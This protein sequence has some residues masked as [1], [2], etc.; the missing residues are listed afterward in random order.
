MWTWKIRSGKS[1]DELHVIDALVA[2]VAR[3]V[4]EA[5]CRVIADRLEGA[6]GEGDVER[7]F[8]GMHF[9]GVADAVV[10][11]LVEDRPEALGEVFVSAV[12]LAGQVRREAV[13]EVP[14]GTAGEAV[15]HLD[16]EL[17]R[18]PGRLLSIPRR[19]V[20]GRPRDRHRP[21]C[22]RGE[23][24]CDVASMLSQTAWPTKCVEMAKQCMPW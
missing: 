14:D 4:V 6:L 17:F 7:D 22:D 3:V 10:L 9:Q 15:D 12:D 1:I 23:S 13:D 11:I 18:R 8:R 24:A 5:E 20:G 19:R 21:R 2:E 16:A